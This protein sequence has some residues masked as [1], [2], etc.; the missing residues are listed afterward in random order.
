VIISYAALQGFLVSLWNHYR[1][2][3]VQSFC[4]KPSGAGDT[5]TCAPLAAKT[6]SKFA[7]QCLPRVLIM[8]QVREGKG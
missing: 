4:V 2:E 6:Q 5:E 3:R 1:R 8:L 7:A